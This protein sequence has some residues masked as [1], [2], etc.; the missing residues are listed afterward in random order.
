MPTTLPPVLHPADLASLLPDRAARRLL[1]FVAA[2]PAFVA[3]GLVFAGV[4]DSCAMGML[5]ARLPYN[6]P[7]SCDVA[8]TARA[9][10]T[11]TVT[12][13]GR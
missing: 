6:R 4:T 7:A 13:G 5:I 11:G 8:A 10:T 2:I 9:L 12:T 3:S 1:A